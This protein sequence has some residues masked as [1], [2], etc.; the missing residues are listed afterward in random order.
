MASFS[1]G[2]LASDSNLSPIEQSLAGLKTAVKVDRDK[3]SQVGRVLA[4]ID[5]HNPELTPEVKRKIAETIYEVSVKYENLDVDLI[6]AT[7]TH[8]SAHTWRPDVISPAG[9]MGLM[10]IMPAT[11]QFLAELEGI[12]WTRAEEILYDPILNI[13]LG[14]RYLSSLIEQY[15]LDGGLAAYNGGERRALMWLA[16]GRDDRVL[17]KETRAYIPAIL[18]LY[19][20]FRD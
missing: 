16:Q 8:E 18:R 20:Q 11:G 14:S 17:W 4:I 1:L 9:A 13:R 19:D 3:Q 12:R 2:I 10:Q 15:E 6:C 7:I 5:R